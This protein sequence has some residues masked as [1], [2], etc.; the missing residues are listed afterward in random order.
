VESFKHCCD[1]LSI[2]GT[3]LTGKYECTMLIAICI[4]AD[5]QL[6]HLTFIIM[7]KENSDSW[8][9]FLHLVRRVVVG[10]GRE[11]CVISNMHAII[12][13]VI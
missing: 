12:L 2:D 10:T 9:W 13:N 7:E 3:F 1:A 5:C 6:V 11:I 8:G 4:D